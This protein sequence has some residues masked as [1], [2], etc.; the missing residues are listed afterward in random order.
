MRPAMAASR[1]SMPL[2]RCRDRRCLKKKPGR[3]DGPVVGRGQGG[4]SESSA[5]ELPLRHGDDELDWRPVQRSGPPR[6]ANNNSNRAAPEFPGRHRI[7]RD[8]RSAKEKQAPYYPDLQKALQPGDESGP[9]RPRP[10]W[11]SRSMPRAGS[12]LACTSATRSKSRLAV[13]ALCNC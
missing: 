2:W 5:S 11:R 10:C 1:R 4:R 9:P 3:A 8:C 12:R 13:A 6:P 7:R